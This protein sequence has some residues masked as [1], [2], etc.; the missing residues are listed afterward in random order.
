M[1]RH[2]IRPKL[3]LLLVE[4][5]AFAILAGVASQHFGMLD[6]VR[7]TVA[8]LLAYLVPR[9]V[10]ER[11]RGTSATA[12][13]VLFLLAAFVMVCNVAYLLEWT[14]DE[15]YSL[16]LPNL[17]SDARKYYKWA[18]NR[19]DGSV[20]AVNVAFPGFPYIIYLLW[21]VLGV[22]V[23]WPQAMNMM[24]TL[25][26]VVLTG[27]TVRRL[28][29]GRVDF[30]EQTLMLGSLVLSGL[31]V[32][33]LV[34]GIHILKEGSIYLSISLAGY[35]LS[36]MSAC[37]EERHHWLRD[38]LLFFLACLILAA[39]RTTFLYFIAVGVVIM[40]L[41]HCR[42]DWIFVIGMLA[43]CAIT[44]L[45]GNHYCNYSFDRHATIV[46]GGMGMQSNYISTE[47]QS[48]Y[49]QIIGEYFLFSTWHRL[50]LLPVSLALQFIIPFPWLMY[51]NVT[52]ANVVSRITVG[53]YAVGCISLF[54]FLFVSWRRQWNMGAWAWWP[55][56]VFAVIAYLMAGTMSRYVLPF[57]PL[58][59]PVV[60]Y[61]LCLLYKGLWRKQFKYW[62]IFYVAL[63]VVTL[64]I[65]FH[66]QK[67]YS[68]GIMPF[69]LF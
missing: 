29:V 24:F 49:V 48:V 62:S 69:S 60:I 51:E 19:Y 38:L 57:Q 1:E 55:A 39:V 16:Q 52:V 31:L 3:L 47:S 63:L 10:L 34:M 40:A 20:S 35:A 21:K 64:I 28:L 32:Y 27:M 37:D 67:N 2:V 25:M 12:C 36:S 14:Q 33:Y 5:I 26:S 42:R 50:A 53:W 66:L 7:I 59:I 8:Y 58:F 41:P 17:Q 23:I 18:L 22:S 68:Q 11:C 46:D 9:I 43:I 44:L 15:G 56:V 54:Y 65:C 61:V 30:S 13:W 4:V 6:G 45:I